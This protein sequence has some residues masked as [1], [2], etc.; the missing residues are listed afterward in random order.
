[1]EKEGHFVPQD[2]SERGKRSTIDQS[3][4]IHLN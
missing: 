2:E 3:D 1:M 4:I